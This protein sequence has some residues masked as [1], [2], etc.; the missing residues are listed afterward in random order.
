MNRPENNLHIAL[1]KHRDVA[2]AVAVAADRGGTG[3]GA[4]NLV[5]DPEAADAIITDTV[6]V[7]NRFQELSPSV[8]LLQLVDCGSGMPHITGDGLTVANVSSLLVDEVAEHAVDL[9]RTETVMRRGEELYSGA[10]DNAIEDIGVI[11][12]GTLGRAVG[13]HL[14]DA[15]P[16]KLWVND[17]RT[18]K[19]TSFQAM[20]AR[21][22]SL[23]MLL[24]MCD[25]ICVAIHRGPT[26]APLLSERELRLVSSRTMIYNLSGPGV[27]D[28]DAVRRL[29]QQSGRGIQYRQLP[30]FIGNSRDAENAPTVAARVLDNLQAFAT[31]R[32]PRGIVEHVTFPSAG[33][34]AFWASQMAPRQLAD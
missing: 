24:S 19:P 12:F 17:I 13:R 21:R 32:Q 8:G 14:R 20:G 29:N 25:F 28:L 9:W 3:G 31:G 16:A 1:P 18:P 33:D 4:W 11:G 7:K 5:D 2:E 26:S 30:P 27:I 15:T 22:S 34:P 10:V 6:T 23:D